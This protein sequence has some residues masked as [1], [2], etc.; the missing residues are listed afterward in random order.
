M[1]SPAMLL[2][3][4]ETVASRVHKVLTGRQPADRLPMLEWAM[5]W[6]ECTI[7]RWHGEGLSK[8][9][10][11]SG[12]KRHLGLDVDHQ[13]WTH[14]ELPELHPAVHGA[15]MIGDSAHYEQHRSRLYRQDRPFLDTC[16]WQGEAGDWR[17]WCAER[18]RGEAV[19]WLTVYGFFWWPRT[20]LGIEP[21][22]YAF[23][24]QP[25]L[26]H[27]INQDQADF[28]T[29][30]LDEVCVHGTPDFVTI[31][32][33]MSYNN[34]PMLSRRQFETFLAPYYRQVLPLFH[35]RG[36]AV[37]CDSDGD[38]S[39]LAPWLREVGFDG[40]LPLEHQAGCDI[41]RLQ[42]ALPDFSFVGHFDK[43]VMKQGEAAMRAE[44]DRLL[45]AMRAGRF[46]PSVDHQTPPDVSLEHYRIYVRL[47]REYAERAVR[48]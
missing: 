21:H 3:P 23:H 19:C 36:I 2:I 34:G 47:F 5:W 22:L 24:D 26:M 28:I 27:R 41:N 9:L 30:W 13:Y 38:V 44:F 29:R 43:M 35:Q 17:S 37:I 39:M 11:K 1:S 45:P 8:D 48:S 33:D 10:D 12:I 25:E 4:A 46:I 32:E 31:A 6:S 40:V 15:A 16:S 42:A 14:Q 20:L 7:A 18:D